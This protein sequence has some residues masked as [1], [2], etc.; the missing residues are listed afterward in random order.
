MHVDYITGTSCFMQAIHILGDDDDLTRPV[1]L[2]A[3][4]RDV[5]G[6]WLCLCSLYPTSIVK[7]VHQ[8][9]IARKTLGRGD[10]LDPVLRPQAI[11]IAE[12]TQTAFRRN[13][14]SSQ[15]DDLFHF[16]SAR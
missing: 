10:I 13:S 6:V 12:S 16:T 8:C 5:S 9:R 3:R 14:G 4:Q 1:L 15:N 11:L 7:S 2:Q